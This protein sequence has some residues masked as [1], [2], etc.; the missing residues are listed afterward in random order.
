MKFVLALL[1]LHTTSC[2]SIFSFPESES[3]VQADLQE[4]LSF[5]Q[6]F[7]KGYRDSEEERMRFF[8]FRSNKR[9]VD[10][11]NLQHSQGLHN[12]TMKL[13]HFSDMLPTEF[14]ATMNGYRNKGRGNFQSSKFHRL[15]TWVSVP[16]SV[17][18]RNEGAVTPVK[19]QGKCGSCWAF[20]STG[21]LEG[22]HFRKTGKL[23]SLSEQNLVDCSTSFG[24]QGCNGGLMDNAFQY[25]KANGGIDT[26]QS[27]PYDAHAEMCHFRRDEIGATDTGFIDIPEGDEEALKHAVAVHGPVSV[28]IDASQQSFQF[29]HEGVYSDAE[30]SSTQL[31]HGV[32]VV[33]YGSET[34]DGGIRQ[35]FWLVKNS[36]SGSWGEEGYIKIA[37]NEG[38]MC[39]IASSASLPL[40]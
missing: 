18:W 12:F 28:A 21:A 10:D 5:K 22:Q 29:Y 20:S 32:L 38:N 17:D 39:G 13:N 23:V 8:I 6:Q 15:P 35:D 40:V 19:N 25:V 33:G 9:K 3:N 4:W 37:R 30:C 31:D 7:D 34:T 16:H 26:E 1:M 24:N 14:V 27:Y 2:L 11:H 36:W